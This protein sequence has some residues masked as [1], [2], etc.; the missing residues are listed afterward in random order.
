VCGD[1]GGCER[2]C[3]VPVFAIMQHGGECK[4]TAGQRCNLCQHSAD[5]VTTAWPSLPNS[6]L[7]LSQQVEVLVRAKPAELPVIVANRSTAHLL[8][9]TLNISC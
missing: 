8:T 3:I 1:A 6:Y 5:L 2:F 9:V 4:P 7:C